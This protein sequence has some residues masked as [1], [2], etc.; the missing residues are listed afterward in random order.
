MTTNNNFNVRVNNELITQFKAIAKKSNIKQVDLINEILTEYYNKRVFENDFL[1]FPNAFYFNVHDLLK[2]KK[3]KAITEPPE[4]NIFNY[5][6]CSGMPINCDIWSIKNNSYCYNDNLKQHKGIL[7]NIFKINNKLAPCYLY[8]NYNNNELAINLYSVKEFKL[9]NVPNKEHLINEYTDLIATN[10][11][12]K[13]EFNINMDI[14]PE[15]EKTNINN[16]ID[17]WQTNKYYIL[18][19]FFIDKIL[20]NTIQDLKAND[21]EILIHGSNKFTINDLEQFFNNNYEFHILEIEF[22][23]YCKET[24]Y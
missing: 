21:K 4:N 22:I 12:M 16:Y 7:F 9:L 5:F 24:I 6:V 8:F 2:Y 13:N 23:K 15:P 1:K 3:V 19:P 17:N 10:N 18:K 11:L 20:N 14:M